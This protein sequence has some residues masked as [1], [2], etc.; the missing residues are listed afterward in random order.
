V[1]YQIAISE[2]KQYIRV[3]VSNA[4]TVGLAKRIFRCASELTEQDSICRLLIDVRGYTNL[5]G[6]IDGYE[7]ANGGADK[8]GLT[9]KWQIAVLT[10]PSETAF[11]FLETVMMN[12]GFC[13]RV[14]TQEDEA[15]AWVKPR[16]QSSASERQ[17]RRLRSDATSP[18][19]G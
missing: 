5:L 19:S 11:D 13:F 16:L 12:A 9:R 3:R 2:D 15:L 6:V 18:D 8:A 7:F 17:K 10:N 4:V 14:F 1:D